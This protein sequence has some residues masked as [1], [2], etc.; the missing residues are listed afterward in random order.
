MWHSELLG[1]DLWANKRGVW[2]DVVRM[3]EHG[4]SVSAAPIEHTIDCVGYVLKEAPR[5]EKFNMSE[6]KSILIQHSNEI[7]QMGFKVP[8]AI[9]SKLEKDRQPIKFSTGVTLEPPKLLVRG[10]RIIILGDTSNASP[11]L[12]LLNDSSDGIVDL[13]IHEATGTS[14]PQLNGSKS[15]GPDGPE[16]IVSKKMLERGHSTSY[17]AGKFARQCKAKMLLLNHLGGKYSSPSGCLCPSS[18]FPMGH[19]SVSAKFRTLVRTALKATHAVLWKTFEETDSSR[20]QK[21]MEESKWLGLVAR[22][23]QKGW[24]D[25]SS[26]TPTSSIASSLEK[27]AIDQLEVCVAYDFMQI[28]IQRSD[29]P[30]G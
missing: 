12:T 27:D 25:E 13:L 7:K 15:E 9:L 5:R 10:R 17:A 21:I 24:K 26:Y 29:Q 2:E 16:A 8:Q 1:E 22:D 6:L 30:S 3:D 4:V 28:K 20:Q 11:I 19:E 23:A 14:V 18:G